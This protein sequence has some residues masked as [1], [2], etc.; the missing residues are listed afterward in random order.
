MRCIAIIAPHTFPLTIKR[1]DRLVFKTGMGGIGQYASP[2]LAQN[3]MKIHNKNDFATT[4][5]NFSC[6]N[7]PDCGQSRIYAKIDLI[8]VIDIFT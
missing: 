8:K 2:A 4:F 3:R 1:T 5:L 7:G 6:V